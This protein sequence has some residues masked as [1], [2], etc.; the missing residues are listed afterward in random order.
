MKVKRCAYCQ[1]DNP[2]EV[3]VCNDCGYPFYGKS[4]VLEVDPSALQESQKSTERS[5]SKPPWMPYVPAIIAFFLG[6]GG[7]VVVSYINLKRLG[8]ERNEI[9]LPLGGISFFCL[10]FF[11]MLPNSLNILGYLVIAG[12]FYYYQEWEFTGWEESEQDAEPDKWWRAVGWGILGA[13][14]Y[15]AVVLIFAAIFDIS[16]GPEPR[17]LRPLR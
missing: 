7:A 2:V 5:N 6:L 16:L 4:E 1:K 3:T 10:I 13:I 11:Y 14:I 17:N 9:I 12:I 8:K 15:L